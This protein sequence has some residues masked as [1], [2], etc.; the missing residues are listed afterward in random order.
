MG[1]ERRGKR[2]PCWYCSSLHLQAVYIEIVKANVL[3]MVFSV[4]E[5]GSMRVFDQKDWMESRMG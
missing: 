4:E 2:L 1:L 5:R 3:R